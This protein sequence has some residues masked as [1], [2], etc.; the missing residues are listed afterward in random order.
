MSKWLASGVDV[1][2]RIQR[3]SSALDPAFA[4]PGEPAVRTKLAANAWGFGT[5]R[6]L[7][8]D[9]WLAERE[10]ARD[11][12]SFATAKRVADAAEQSATSAARA[13]RVAW[14]AIYVSMF[15]ISF[16]IIIWYYSL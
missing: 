7:D 2:R 1:T 12:D 16:T 10:L 11:A 8:V 3:K 6:R 14:I 15:A 13:V 5:P 9:K 4:E